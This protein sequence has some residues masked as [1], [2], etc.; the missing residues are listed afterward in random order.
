MS[1][2]KKKKKATKKA[3]TA[4]NKVVLVPDNARFTVRL[5]GV[6][7]NFLR[8]KV[9]PRKPLQRGESYNELF[10]RLLKIGVHNDGNN[11][12]KVKSK[13]TKRAS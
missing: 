5:D 10:K 8:S 13:S 3:K 1:S 4:A 2:L 7:I 9:K 6:V 11:D 12:G